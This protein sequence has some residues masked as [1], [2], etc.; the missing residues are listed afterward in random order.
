MTPTTHALSRRVFLAAGGSFAVGVAFGAWPPDGNAAVSTEAAGRFEPGAFIRIDPDDTITLTMPRVEMGQGTYTALSMLI[1][2]ELEVP[3]ARVRVEHAPADPARYGNPRAGGAQL[4]GGSSSIRGAWEPLRVAGATARVMLVEAAALDWAVPVEDCH[5][6]DGAVIHTPTGRTLGYGRLA[7]RAAA[8]PLPKDVPLKPPEAFKLVGRPVRRVDAPGKVDGSARYG[9]DV[10]LPGMRFATVASSPVLGGTLRS[11]DAKD[12]LAVPGVRQVV[13]IANAVAV[14]ADHTWAARQGL[15]A[16]KVE[17]D[18]GPSA[19]VSMPA[20]TADLDRALACSKAAIALLQGDVDAAMQSGTA[21]VEATYHSPFLAHAALEPINCTVDC[22]PDACEVWVGTQAPVRARDAAARASGLPADKVTVHNF[23]LGGSFGRRLEADYVE[24]CVALAAQVQGPVQFIW[25][26]E[27]DIQH[28][29]FRPVYADHF[30]AA[31]DSAGRPLAVTHRVAGSSIFSRVAPARVT[32]GVDPDAVELGLGPYQWPAAR[33]DYVRQEPMAGMTTG[34]WRGVGPTHN[35][36][37]VESFVDELAAAATADP[38]A[39]RMA[40]LPPTSRLRNVLA[41]V[42]RHGGWDRPLPSTTGGRRGRGVSVL[43][44]WGTS[45]AML[46]EVTVDA[47]GEI[48]VDRV[49]C[50]V[51]CGM[52]V[53]PDTVEAQI[54]GGV[55]FGLGAALWGEITIQDGR[56]LQSNFHDYR[57]LRLSEAPKVEVHIVPSREAPGGVGEPGTS[58]IFPALAN[59]VFNATGQRLRR[60]P[61]RLAQT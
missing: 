17:W 56:V 25:T 20:I 2:E 57:V 34:W 45:L 11:V 9:I 16:L 41:L 19:G 37:V 60:L 27:E 54:D 49:V 33:L 39:Y 36:F 47:A 51:D 61:L 3:L 7:R 58:A 31:C 10:R 23:L 48:R 12:A 53:N 18:D 46:A 28:D 44:A 4:T 52:V 29:A 21:K 40:L 38:L 24:Q 5:A 15:G 59:A 55:M 6:R 14:V 13:K 1:A 8:L 30:V 22:R 35:C 43:E 26:R 50:V 42:G 32:H